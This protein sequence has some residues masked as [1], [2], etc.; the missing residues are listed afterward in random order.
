MKFRVLVCGLI[1]R[2]LVWSCLLVKI[3]AQIEQQKCMEELG[4]CLSYLNDSSRPSD[5]CCQPLDYVINSIPE[6][7][8]SF[9]SFL[10]LDR[11]PINVSKL[12]TLPTRCGHEITPLRCITGTPDT[13][14]RNMAPN[15]ASPEIWSSSPIIVILALH[16]I[17][18]LRALWF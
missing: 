9:I 1:A 2:T 8:C 13:E 12:L 6:C 11:A 18:I 5:S 16:V 14:S 10:G 7:L 15:S 17:L 4:F 3:S